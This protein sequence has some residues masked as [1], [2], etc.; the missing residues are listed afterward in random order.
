MNIFIFNQFFRLK[1]DGE[2]LDRNKL[3]P[4]INNLNSESAYQK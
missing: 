4:Y 1:N 2:R 3:K